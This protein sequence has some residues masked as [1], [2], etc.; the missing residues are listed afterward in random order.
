MLVALVLAGQ[1][2]LVDFGLIKR[3]MSE[4]EV[5]VGLGPPDYES[6]EGCASNNLLIKSY[7]YFSGPGRHQDITTVIKFKGG[8]VIR[9]E[10]ICR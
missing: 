8:R 1:V 7:F 3:G 4:A 2:D 10:R 6:F 9:K 5:L